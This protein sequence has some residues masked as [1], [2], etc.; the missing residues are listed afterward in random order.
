LY[1]GAPED[2]T[3]GVLLST[4]AS[5]S[6]G[7]L[8]GLVALGEPRHLERLLGEAFKAAECCSSDPLCAEH[9]PSFP[10]TATT[11]WTGPCW[12]TSPVT[13]SPSA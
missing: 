5:D 12:L 1:L 13:T 11:G 4:A 7:T 9:V 6:E 2:P 3:A 10:S 8:G